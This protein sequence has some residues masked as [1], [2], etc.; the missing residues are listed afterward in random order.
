MPA[1]YE[2]DSPK[3]AEMPN[4]AAATAKF[5]DAYFD[6]AAMQLRKA[7]SRFVWESVD[8]AKFVQTSYRAFPSVERALRAAR[9]DQRFSDVREAA[10]P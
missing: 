7:A 10:A 2:H 3:G 9:A 8:P 1:P 4:T 6:R 5:T